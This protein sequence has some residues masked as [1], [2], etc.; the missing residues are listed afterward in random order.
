MDTMNNEPLVVRTASSP[1]QGWGTYQHEYVDAL[2]VEVAKH[3]AAVEK[4]INRIEIYVCPNEVESDCPAIEDQQFEE[5]C[6][7]C[8][9]KW[10]YG[11]EG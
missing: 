11:G 7:E 10:A 3:K 8:W 2:E 4:L 6:P 1:R 5:R 9:R